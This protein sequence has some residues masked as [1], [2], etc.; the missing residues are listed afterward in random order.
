MRDSSSRPSARPSA[1]VCFLKHFDRRCQATETI[2]FTIDVSNR[3]GWRAESLPVQ[4]M[5]PIWRRQKGIH[6]QRRVKTWETARLAEGPA[7]P[8][9]CLCPA[10]VSLPRPDQPNQTDDRV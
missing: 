1:C 7:L 2:R 8:M 9:P 3:E 6:T 4:V 10:C 5:A